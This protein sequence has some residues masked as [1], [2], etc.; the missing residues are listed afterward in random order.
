[1]ME[2]NGTGSN[3]TTFAQRARGIA[4][5]ITRG[6]RSHAREWLHLDTGDN[7]PGD[8]GASVCAE[9]GA[10]ITRAD[11]ATAAAEKL[12]GTRA[13]VTA[14]EIDLAM[15]CGAYALAALRSLIL[16]TLAMN[17]ATMAEANRVP[18]EIAARHRGL[19][20]RLARSLAATADHAPNLVPANDPAAAEVAERDMGSRILN[21][22]C[23]SAAPPDRHNDYTGLARRRRSVR[24]GPAR[25]PAA[26]TPRPH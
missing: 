15:T 24:A 11:L 4:P 7:A 19:A 8:N 9:V 21:A 10:I 14:A 22:L 20:D 13:R 5:I 2:D 17:L 18:P 25:R 3:A 1:M 16:D 26:G 6:E 23:A 12:R